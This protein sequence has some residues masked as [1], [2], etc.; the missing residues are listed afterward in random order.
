MITLENPL[1]IEAI[2]PGTDTNGKPVIKLWHGNLKHAALI[3]R[4]PSILLSA[5]ID[6]GTLK[7]GK[8]PVLLLAHWQ[9]STRTNANGNPHKDVIKLENLAPVPATSGTETANLLRQVLAE[10]L[11]IREMLIADGHAAAAGSVFDYFYADG[12]PA[13]IP[14]EKTAFNDYRRANDEK[15]PASRD[16]LREWWKA[17]KASPPPATK[18]ATRTGRPLQAQMN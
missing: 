10:L 9:D 13:T 4:S 16:A 11:E 12:E 14:E 8:T 2:E 3:A 5:G 17:K 1:L 18:P 15:A 7:P 6:P